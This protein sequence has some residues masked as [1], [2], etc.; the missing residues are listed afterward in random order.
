[1][2]Y[3]DWQT[4]LVVNAEKQLHDAFG[5]TRTFYRRSYMV[6]KAV[7]HIKMALEYNGQTS[8]GDVLG[9]PVVPVPQIL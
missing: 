1:M 5:I 4:N 7:L 3:A 8:A 6:T 2:L 9:R